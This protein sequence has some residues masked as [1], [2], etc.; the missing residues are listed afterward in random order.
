[1]LILP[2]DASI[3]RSDSVIAFASRNQPPAE[4]VPEQWRARLGRITREK[5]LPRIREF[6]QGGGT[7]LAV[8]DAS[9][10]AHQLDL[11]VAN[12]LVGE[13]G[14]S[15]PRAKYYVP[16]SVLSVAVDTT[17]PIG[18]GMERRTDVFYDNNPA[19][20]LE[21]DARSKGVRSVAW[22]DSQTPLRSGWAWGQKIL[23]GAS[24][25]V[26]APLGRGSVVLYGP[27]VHFR[28]Q[29]HGAFPFLFNGIFY[30]QTR[31]P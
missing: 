2:D 8:G 22:F 16:G 23:D 20:R 19:F 14:K 3:D 9:E 5:S 30:G 27:Q 6:V 12:A 17:N 11:P 4:K 18:W 1:M 26:V 24:E 25:V 28:G 21:P 13:D 29:T 15:L 31:R 10:I 7:L